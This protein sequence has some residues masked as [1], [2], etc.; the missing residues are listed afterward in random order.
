MSVRVAFLGGLGEGGRNCTSI[1]IDGR[2]ALIDCGLGFPEEDMLGVDLSAE[3]R[4]QR[5]QAAFERF[6]A[7]VPRLQRLAGAG[8]AGRLGRAAA[9]L[10][11]TLHV[12]VGLPA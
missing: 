8:T 2:L 12:Q 6:A 3:A 9:E 7:L 5:C 1:E 4:Q 11:E 10:L